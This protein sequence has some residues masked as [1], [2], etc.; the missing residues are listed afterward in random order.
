[1]EWRFVN[2][3]EFIELEGQ[4]KSEKHPRKCRKGSLSDQYGHVIREE[5]HMGDGDKG[6]V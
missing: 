1:M 5:E 6:P 4:C 2:L 3:D